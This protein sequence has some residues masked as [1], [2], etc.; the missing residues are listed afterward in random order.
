[1]PII[2]NRDVLTRIAEATI[3]LVALTLGGLIYIRYR[4]ENLLMFDWFDN[5]N[6]SNFIG[7]LR[8]STDGASLYGWIKYNMPAGLW[9]FSYMF[10]IDSVWGK[11]RNICYMCFLY[12]LPILAIISELMQLFKLLPGTFDIMDILSYSLAILIFLIIKKLYV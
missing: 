8:A 11:D 7:G 12:V 1:M 3:G 6:L 9:L 4:S 5:L 10:V 2:L